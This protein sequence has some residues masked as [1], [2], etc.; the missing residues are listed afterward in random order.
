VSVEDN[1]AWAQRICIKRDTNGA[2]YLKSYD[3]NP[4]RF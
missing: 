2:T 1:G 3:A 4:K